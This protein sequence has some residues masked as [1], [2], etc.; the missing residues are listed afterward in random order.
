MNYFPVSSSNLSSVHLGDFLKDTYNLNGDVRCSL[1]RA[2]VN[3]TYMLQSGD[4][5]F[6]FRVYSLGWRTRLE[7]E[8]ELKLV[9]RLK[10]N[11]VPVSY[12]LADSQ[13]N[14]IQTLN[15]PEGDR[16]GVLFSFAEGK[17]LHNYSQ[18]LHRSVGIIMA[19][20]HA[21]TENLRIERTK[22]TWKLLLEEPFTY[23][24]QFISAESEEMQF[25]EKAAR[26][27][28]AQLSTVNEKH[29]RHGVIHLDIWFDNLNITE[30]G[31]I[32][33]FDFDFCGNG[34]LCIDVAYYML[35]LYNV[36]R[37]EESRDKKLAA[38]FKGYE[39]ISP[40]SEDE[41]RILPMLG[42]A[43]YVFYLGVQ[44][45][46]YENWSNSF[47]SESYLKRFI[48]QLVKRYYDLHELG[49]KAA[50]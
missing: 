28:L 31:E 12:P 42:V 15:A 45:S 20:M 21:A 39:S 9:G 4:Q 26:L 40:L 33:L 5:R 48:S 10:A 22:Y 30:S 11:A 38:F 43:L 24:R 13:G 2:G 6:V 16:Y 19:R 17:K 14:H 41:K 3:H 7:I 25:L 50:V 34:W 8:E 18:D 36:E 27:L 46:R 44:C 49:N 37:D 23:I 35:Q 47:L 1:I 29:L 32:T